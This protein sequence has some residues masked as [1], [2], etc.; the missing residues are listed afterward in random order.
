MPADPGISLT[1]MIG[2]DDLHSR[3]IPYMLACNGIANQ[4]RNACNQGLFSVRD[5]QSVQLLP[6]PYRLPGTTDLATQS[7]KWPSIQLSISQSKTFSIRP[8]NAKEKEKY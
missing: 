2:L 3:R 5:C 4:P 7:T 1:G 8:S 6:S